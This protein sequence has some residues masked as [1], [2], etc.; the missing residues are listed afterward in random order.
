[1]NSLN[2]SFLYAEFENWG[3]GRN[4]YSY[5]F[6]VGLW[7]SYCKNEIITSIITIM[8]IIIFTECVLCARRF[9][10]SYLIHTTIPFTT[11]GH[12]ASLMVSDRVRLPILRGWL[13]LQRLNTALQHLSAKFY[14]VLEPPE[15]LNESH[16]QIPHWELLTNASQYGFKAKW[17]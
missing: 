3:W 8:I 4:Q 17:P 1:M 12:M 5:Y 2:F 10:L 15:E 9:T 14:G 16:Q 13:R 7:I 11:R 6:T